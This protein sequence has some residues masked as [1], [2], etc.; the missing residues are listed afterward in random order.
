M[1]ATESLAWSQLSSCLRGIENPAKAPLPPQAVVRIKLTAVD[2]GLPK[3]AFLECSD[4]GCTL[5]PGLLIGRV[6]VGLPPTLQCLGF[7]HQCPLLGQLQCCRPAGGGSMLPERNILSFPRASRPIHSPGSAPG[8]P[9]PQ[10]QNSG[11]C[12]SP[13][14]STLLPS[15]LLERPEKEGELTGN[16]GA[17]L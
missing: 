12:C 8:Q 4:T 11:C 17:P 16:P 15:R 2:E 13:A 7:S 1:S 5:G 14:I 6:A 3:W 9:V 10:S